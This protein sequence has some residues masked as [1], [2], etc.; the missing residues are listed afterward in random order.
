MMQTDYFR[1]LFLV[2]NKQWII[3]NLRKYIDVENF[4][5]QE[6]Y[7]IKVYQSL[8]DEEEMEKKER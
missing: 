7:L 8:V 4:Y 2:S 3:T 5:D 6:G 1:Q